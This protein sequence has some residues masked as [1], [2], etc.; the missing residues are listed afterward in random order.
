MRTTVKRK[1][2]KK[3]MLPK[4][5][6]GYKIIGNNTDGYYFIFIIDGERVP[7]SEW[8]YIPYLDTTHARRLVDIAKR[9]SKS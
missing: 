3:W 8:L 2:I 1:P 5:G 4:S 7:E 9:I 6:P